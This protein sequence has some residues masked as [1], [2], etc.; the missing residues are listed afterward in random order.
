VF[1]PPD[2][3]GAHQTR[4]FSGSLGYRGPC[5]G[6][7]HTYEF[8]IYA[9]DIAALPNLNM[10]SSVEDATVQALMHDLGVAKLTGMYTP[11]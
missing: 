2:V 5:P 10:N 6:S 11:Q 3:P 1:A 4:S 9:L 7:T 8:A